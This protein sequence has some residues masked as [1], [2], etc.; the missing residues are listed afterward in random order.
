MN[1]LIA[2]YLPSLRGGGAERVMVTLANGFSK[3]GHKVDLVL[4]RAEG[5]Y[6]EDVSSSVRVID[7]GASRVLTSLP[8]LVRYL[9]RERPT[10]L[11]SALSHANL[12]AITAQRLSCISSRVVVSEHSHHSAAKAN[13][14][15]IR[16]RMNMFFMR[17]LYPKAD[18]IV[19]VSN[20]VALDL[21][22]NIGLPFRQVRTI[23]NP[24]TDSTIQERSYEPL[25]HPW[26]NPGEPPVILGVGR[27][28]APKD[29]PMLIRA[30][31][32]LRTRRAVRLMILGEGELRPKLEEL[33][34]ELG[35]NAD[36]EL[37]GFVSNPF[38]YMRR[39]ALY[40]LSSQWEA[41]GN[42]LVEAMACGSPVVATDCPGGP[43]EILEKGRWGRLVPV[44]DAD[45]LANAMIE[46]LDAVEPPDVT[47]RAMD[48]SVD[49]AVVEYMKLLVVGLKSETGIRR[50]L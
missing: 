17:W 26:F 16:E 13:A 29:F 7:L 18:G 20:S 44:G 31:A 41:F 8:G 27:L 9:R 11:L 46:T 37:P 1:N 34:R 3:R 47:I 10:A 36:V 43:A 42:V 15:L 28:A 30:F 21:A 23:G 12:V 45:A 5:P 4:A 35:L 40:V 38:A 48:F 14:K 39:A 24:V 2:I 49:K 33:V 19:A 50:N 22:Q 32:K 25:N 6:L